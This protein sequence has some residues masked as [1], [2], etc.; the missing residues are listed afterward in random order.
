[1][2]DE[3]RAEPVFEIHVECDSALDLG[4]R[5]WGKERLIPI[6]GGQVSGE[7]LRGEVLHGGADKQTVRTDGVIEIEARYTLR[8]DD[9]SLIYVC[10][11]GLVVL[12]RAHT[13]TPSEASERQAE[14]S[15]PQDSRA[16]SPSGA[17]DASGNGK[18]LPYVRSVPR[19]EA[20]MDGP[21]SWL[22]QS[23][24][25]ATI[26]LVSGNAPLNVRVRVFRV[27]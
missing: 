9:A 11:Q 16:E 6:I 10:N 19:F 25:L 18:A 23:I 13:P 2:S 8:A 20:P 17:S 14:A 3:L 21:H 12:P 5:P 27:T 4:M 15:H 1:M 24:F 7:R 22:N 26:D